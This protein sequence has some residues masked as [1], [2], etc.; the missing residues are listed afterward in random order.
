[1]SWAD[2]NLFDAFDEDDIGG[3]DLEYCWAHGYHITASGR[4]IPIKK[5]TDQHLQNT[6]NLM[7]AVP[8][9]VRLNTNILERELAR[10]EKII[11]DN[12]KLKR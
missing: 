10:R 2:D 3:V 9:N 1:M 7:R 4:E 5:M 8:A 12:M 11:S 6:I